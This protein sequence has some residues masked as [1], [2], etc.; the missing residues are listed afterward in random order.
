MPKSK[1]TGNGIIDKVVDFGKQLF[2]AILRSRTGALTELSRLSRFQKGSKGFEREYNRLIPLI[3]EIKEAF[4]KSVVENFPSQGLRLGI[5]DDSDIEKTGKYFPKQKI[6]HNHTTDTF[7]SGMKVFSSAVYQ[8]KKMSIVDSR[9][10]GKEDNKLDVAKGMVDVLIAKFLVGIFLFDCW[11]CK[12]PL[13]EYIQLRGKQFIS[14]LRRDTKAELGEDEERLDAL[15]KC[16]P[17]SEYE[18]VN[19][20]GKPYWVKDIVMD[21]KSYGLVRVIISKEGQ[22][23][24]PIFLITN[25]YNFTAK[26]I[27]A[28]YLTRFSIE[29][30]FKDAKQFLNFETFLCRNESKWDLHLL[31][32]N[33]LHW[34]IQRRNSISITVRSIREN[35]ADCL[36]FINKNP[37]IE[38]FFEELRKR[39]Q[40]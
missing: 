40:T 10:V 9:I 14:R 31:I 28:L 15:F 37:L 17:H 20:H 1:R 36:L 5:F 12:S 7:Y 38:Y 2:A 26:F 32:T 16:I 27:V 29:V 19:I 3:N 30:F 34:A 4:V 11:Y 35:I 6:Q 13:L 25:N 18:Q 39:C 8:N 21:L 23:D 22:H 33:V 24:E